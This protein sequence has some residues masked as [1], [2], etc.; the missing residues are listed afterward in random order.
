MSCTEIYE[1]QETG[2]GE[3]TTDIDNAWRGSMFIWR[4]L[5]DKYIS[6]SLNLS[7][8]EDMKE[9]WRLYKDSRLSR[10]EKIVL[11]STFDYAF[12]KREELPEVIEAFK[13]FIKEFHSDNLE[14]QIDVMEQIYK[15]N[16]IYCIGW[17]QTSVNSFLYG[18]DISEGKHWFVMEEEELKND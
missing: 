4:S 3:H 18:Y 17:C 15:E 14:E 2:V 1:F 16:K 7:R 9:I 6:D 8:L 12:V 5:G 13:E 10:S 11:L